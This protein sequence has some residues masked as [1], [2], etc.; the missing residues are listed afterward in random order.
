MILVKLKENAKKFQFSK[1]EKSAPGFW[2][3]KSLIVMVWGNYR[4]AE[5]TTKN[6]HHI[7]GL[8]EFP[9]TYINK[10]VMAR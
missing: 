1:N 4:N 10:R 8:K 3:C 5:T 2:V 6:S 7:K 9:V